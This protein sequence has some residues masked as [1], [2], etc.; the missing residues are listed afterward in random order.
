MEKCHWIAIYDDNTSLKQFNPDG[1]ENLFK[2]IQQ[3]KLK[4]FALVTPTKNLSVFPKKGKFG[5][6]SLNGT[7]IVETRVAVTFDFDTI[8]KADEFRLVYFKR[9]RKQLGQGNNITKDQDVYNVG[10][11]ATIDET[12]YVRLLSYDNGNISIVDKK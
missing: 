12:N 5:I 8:K 7:D 1:S 11:Q 6:F 2:D 9:T 3:D 4:E 10:L